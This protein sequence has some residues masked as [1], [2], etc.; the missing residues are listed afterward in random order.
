MKMPINP[1]DL[2]RAWGM[3]PPWLWLLIA[4]VILWPVIKRLAEDWFDERRFARAGLKD[5]KR[6]SGEDFEKYL[7][8]LFRALGYKVKRTPYQGDYGADLIVTSPDGK[9]FAVQAKRWRGRTV[10][11]DALYEVLGG[12]AYYKCEGT[13]VIT[14][15]KYSE[16]A[17]RMAAETGT[18]LWGLN[19]LIAAMEKVKALQKTSHRKQAV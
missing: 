19:D 16:A 17:K 6:M 3:F 18:Q 9:R 1:L 4:F 2:F 8:H 13:I 5:I 15:S 11:N 14:T 7:E 10:G 12:Q